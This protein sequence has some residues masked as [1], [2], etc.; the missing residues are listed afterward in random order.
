MCIVDKTLRDAEL[1]NVYG[2]TQKQLQEKLNAAGSTINSLP[3]GTFS[4]SAMRYGLLDVRLGAAGTGWAIEAAAK[5]Q[6]IVGKSPA[7]PPAAAATQARP[8]ASPSVLTGDS[9]S[10][11]ASSSTV[12]PRGSVLTVLTPREEVIEIDPSGP[13]PASRQRRIQLCEH[14]KDDKKHAL[15]KSA[16]KQK[17][18]GTYFSHT[19]RYQKSEAYRHQMQQQG[20]P[21]WLVFKNGH[22]SRVDGRPGDQFA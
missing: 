9:P 18:L 21:E 14:L 3:R 15:N 11:A 22:T 17:P 6:R 12:R 10:G 13:G 1:L 4:E 8:H 20:T 5:R 2:L 16:I 19:D 7:P